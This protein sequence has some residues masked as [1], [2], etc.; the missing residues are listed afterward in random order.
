MRRGSRGIRMAVL[1]AAAAPA[2]PRPGVAQE[3]RVVTE[4]EP[5]EIT[6][7]DRIHVTVAVE[8][9]AGYRVTFPDSLD[10]SPFEVT[11]VEM[12]EPVPEGTGYL[13]I[14]RYTL[15]VFQLGELEIPAFEVAVVAPDGS[16]QTLE[17]S[18]WGVV[19]NSVGLDEGGDIRG[20]KAPLEIPLSALVILAWILGV[21]LLAAAGFWLYRRHARQ[22]AAEAVTVQAPLRRPWEI[23][24]DAL[25]ELEA[26]GLLERGEI[27]LYYIRVSEVIRAYVEAQCGVPALEMASFEVVEGLRAT[28]MDEASVRSFEGFFAECDLV[29]FAKFRPDPGHAREIVPRARRLV[30]RTKVGRPMPRR[31]EMAAVAAPELA[32]PEHAQPDSEEQEREPEEPEATP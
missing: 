4:V 1:L 29:K 10:L 7:G 17:T 5:T 8:H 27:K 25:R 13:S 20:I 16:A 2:A 14:A 28:G 6:V 23:A 19:V 21:L 11:D 22:P 32:Q 30:D 12:Q 18:P 15:T 24:E 26:S 9:D 31:A 3:P